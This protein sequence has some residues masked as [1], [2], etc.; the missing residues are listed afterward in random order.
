M[1]VCSSFMVEELKTALALYE[2][3]DSFLAE[4]FMAASVEALAEQWKVR[5]VAHANLLKHRS[6]QF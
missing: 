6:F 1:G 2:L 4:F 3:K 5:N